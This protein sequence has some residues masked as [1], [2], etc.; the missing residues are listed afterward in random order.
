MYNHDTQ[1][2]VRYGE[3]DQ[4]GYVYY[5]NY[6]S[7]FE[8][9]RVEALRALGMSYARLE[10]SG[11]MMPVLENYSKYLRPGR[12]DDLLTIRTTV[13][14]LPKVRM[15]F[16]YQILN[17]EGKTIHQGWTL[18]AFI[19]KESGRPQRAPQEMIEALSPFFNE[20]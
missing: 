2:R 9:G 19:N 4:M 5:G 1:L 17:Q 14:E 18:L 3:T 16:E 11:V 12:Y 6:A 15:K 10:E 7:F 20:A 13:A 8:M